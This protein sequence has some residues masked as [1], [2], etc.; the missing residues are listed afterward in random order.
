MSEMKLL[1]HAPSGRAESWLFLRAKQHGRQHRPRVLG[2][3]EGQVTPEGEKRPGPRPSAPSAPGWGRAA[4]RAP[5]G[6]WPPA[7]CWG[8]F[9]GRRSRPPKWQ[10]CLSGTDR[11]PDAS[12]QR[13][14]LTCVTVPCP[15]S[16]LP[17]L[18]GEG[19]PSLQDSRRRAG[20]SLLRGHARAPRK[21]LPRGSGLPAGRQS[22]S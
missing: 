22:V 19:A 10:L 12:P 1:A 3:P 20:E 13:M 6:S 15:R 2:L 21:T 9:A 4:A 17:R 14:G 5:W 11:A 16:R 18:P 8:R 7:L